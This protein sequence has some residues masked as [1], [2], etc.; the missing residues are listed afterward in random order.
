[1]FA[2][3]KS[4]SVFVEGCRSCLRY[5]WCL[6]FF[7]LPDKRGG[8]RRFLEL[9]VDEAPAV[10]ND[11]IVAAEIGSHEGRMGLMTSDSKSITRYQFRHFSGEG[12]LEFIQFACSAFRSLLSL[13]HLE[14]RKT[15]SGHSKVGPALLDSAK[16]LRMK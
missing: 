9:R 6:S 8:M 11:T 5:I 2:C 7:A 15:P 12:V 3:L 13:E 1:M 10:V 16:R 14:L 4:V